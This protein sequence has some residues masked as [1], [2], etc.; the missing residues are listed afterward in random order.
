MTRHGNILGQRF[1]G[2]FVS[3]SVLSLILLSSGC[4]DDDQ[5]SSPDK[6]L[7]TT[8][9]AAL[10]I[11]WHNASEHPE[12]APIVAAALDCRAIDV[13]N[14]ACDVY[15]DPDKGPVSG[16]PWPCSAGSGRVAGIPVGEN[17]TFVILAENADGNVIYQGEKGGQSI[18][19]G[20]VNDI[21]V[22][23]ARPFVTTLVAPTDGDTVDGNAVS[24]QWQRVENAHQ[25]RVLVAT[26]QAFDDDVVVDAITTETSY[27]PSGLAPFGTYYWRIHCLDVHGNQGTGSKEQWFSTSS[28][29][30]CRPP[31]LDHIN[32]QEV[33]EG[34]RLTFT[35]S[36]SDPDAD[37]PLRFSASGL[38][39]GVDFNQ[40]TGE[41][42]WNTTIGD[43][44]NY[45]VSF[46]VRDSC[47][48]GPLEDS[49][50]VIISVGDV[51]RPP[52]WEAIHDQ[53][54]VEGEELTFTIRASDPDIGDQLT[55]SIDE[56]N[57]NLPEDAD[58]ALDPES[59]EFS[60]ITAI[61]EAGE[62]ET[63]FMVCDDCEDGPLCAYSEPITI[64]VSPY[65][66]I[67][68]TL[69]VTKDG[70][71][72][73]T[74]S[75]SPSGINCGTG[76]T[77]DSHDYEDGTQVTLT[78]DPTGNSTFD[79]WRGGGCSGTGRCTVTMSQARTVTARFIIPESD[80]DGVEFGGYCWYHG[81]Q[82]TSCDEVCASHGGYHEATRYFA[83][84][85]GSNQNCMDVLGALGIHEGTFYETAQGGIGCFTISGAPYRYRDT[86][87][88]T[89]S[90]TYGT[91]GR[92]RVC[93]CQN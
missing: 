52:Q 36:A 83:G 50:D 57:F 84:S 47:P 81:A 64:T 10:T 7:E 17:R 12:S 24:L 72:T 86:Q 85:D 70:D 82:N 3:L 45:T 87:T 39:E 92:R 35:V 59:G 62:Y 30:T 73:G 31:V 40:D 69:T 75:T 63:T 20:E 65:M 88:T 19:A 71:G 9:S 22:I 78:A 29:L 34:D 33:D 43:E 13:E 23:D 32:N 26:G 51:C 1:R 2:L 61:G 93:A 91:P 41:F 53:D 76:C 77:A 55:Y 37:D 16:G 67:D 21:G 60:W 79:G 15:Y 25:Y 89:A 8:A 18:K 48:D 14:V 28:P 6:S 46:T 11:R 4:G 54:V 74:V 44:G 56:D 80:C 5:S 68:Y 27:T 58:Y 42:S 49:Q 38:P 66:T 90:A